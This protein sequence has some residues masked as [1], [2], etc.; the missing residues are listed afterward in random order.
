MEVK[1]EVRVIHYPKVIKGGGIYGE[2]GDDDCILKIGR[3]CG[4]L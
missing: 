3:R 1:T 4:S 2:H